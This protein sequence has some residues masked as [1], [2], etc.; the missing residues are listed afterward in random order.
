MIPIN[1]ILKEHYDL[2][3]LLNSEELF[4]GY[5]NRS[6]VIQVDRNGEQLKYLVRQYNPAIDEKEIRFEHALINHLRA[7]GVTMVAGVIPKRDGSTY[8]KETIHAEGETTTAF[9][10]IFE[11]LKG[12][13]RY[14]WTDTSVTPEEMTSASRVLARLHDAGRDFVKPRGADR[15]QPKI[16][17]LLPTIPKIYDEYINRAGN[18]QCDHL[19]LENVDNILRIIGKAI[20]PESE[21]ERMPQLPVHCDYHQGNLKYEDSRVIGV[22]DF[23]WSK[24]D[25][26]LFDLALAIVYFCASWEGDNAG[27]LRLNACKLFLRNYN[28]AC[29]ISGG[30]TPLT[31]I[32]TKYLPTMIAAANLFVLHWSIVDFYTKQN[33]DDDEY[34]IYMNHNIKLMVWIEEN[35]PLFI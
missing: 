1:E 15:A 16:M 11:F 8:F 19:F 29:K 13:D 26:R 28:E 18:T 3:V 9:W 27:S 24:I 2:G 14:T 21:L 22:F 33:P 12:E 20:I 34:L 31:E 32:E 7:N 35:K 17:N 5:V 6:F 10:A 25:V 4:D 30:L 23:D